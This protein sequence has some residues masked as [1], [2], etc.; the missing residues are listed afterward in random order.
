MLLTHTKLPQLKPRAVFPLILAK[1]P[2]RDTILTINV[3]EPGLVRAVKLHSKHMGIPLKGLVLVHTGYADYPHRPKDTTGLFEE[4][5][6]DFDD[7]DDLQRVLKPY[8]DRL[9]LATCRYEEAIQPFGKV[10]P[11]LPYLYTPSEKSL[12]WATEKPQ[13]RDRL[14]NYDESLVP[15][16]QY[17]EAE[18]L[19]NLKK[20]TKDFEYPVIVKPS[21]L[22]KA[23]L[24][25]RCESETQL[26]KCLD[27]TFKIIGNAYTR[28][29]YPG[30]P[31]VLVEEMMQ[32]DMYSI[33]AY[34][35]HEGKIS[36]L[37]P[38]RVHTAHSRGLQGFYGYEQF[39]PSGLSNTEV[40]AAFNASTSAVR[41]LNLSST[42]AHIEL[43]HTKE[44][45]KIIEVAARIGGFR[46]IL[47]REVYG[48]EH[49][50]NDLSVRMGKEPIMP[51]KPLRHAM[52][53]KIYA[54][55][56]GYIE[57]IKGLEEARK[58][59]SVVYISD[60]AKPNDLALFV[61]NG[62]DPVVDGIISGKD[63]K[64]LVKDMAKIRQ[65]IKIKIKKEK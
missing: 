63:P 54:D 7:P 65:L 26:K 39:L 17:M 15:R 22:A 43:F 40:Q 11:F 34:V 20:L 2:R 14:R 59:K 53:F 57:S 21:G 4:I 37:P 3:V 47:Y 42:T 13:M 5:V 30:K 9:L 32:G 51:C 10:I 31:S 23:F 44:G 46:D 27:N 36:C 18:D 24:V 25:N 58:I 55:D 1:T 64:Q 16:Y 49:F 19:P 62:G 28:E 41:A 60:H 45:W 48:I 29:H 35:S 6:C 61:M 33:D 12:T 38:V 50:Y 8:T 56:E 52:A